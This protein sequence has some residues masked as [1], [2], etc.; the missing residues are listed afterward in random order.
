M[1][2]WIDQTLPGQVE[3]LQ[4]LVRIPSV[5][6]GEKPEPG[7]PFGRKVYE[8]LSYTLDLANRLGFPRTRSLDGYCG[9]VDFGDAD[10]QLLIISHLDVVPAD[11]GWT[12]DPFGGTVRDGRLY[13]RG[14]IDNKSAAVSSLYALAAVKAAGIPLRRSVR[15]LFGC[16]EERGSDC[17]K[18]YRKFEKD[19]TLGFTPDAEYPLV[20]SEKGICQT[21]WKKPFSGSGIRISCGT[22]PNVIPGEA[23]AALPFAAVPCE[24]PEGFTVVFSGN[25]IRATG[26]C[27]HAAEPDL[28]NNALLCLVQV[29]AQQPLS[30]EDLAAATALSAL[31]GLDK[32]GE[33]LGLDIA[34]ESGRLTL[35]PDMLTWDESG[36]TL[37]CDCRY[38]FSCTFEHLLSTLTEC[39]N[40]VGFSLAEHRNAPGLFMA[41]DSELVKT[42]LSVYEEHIGHKA[43]PLAIGG[44]TYARAFPNTVAFGLVKEGEASQCHMPDESIAIEDIR[45]N[46]IV[47]AEAVRRL[48]GK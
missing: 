45:F 37:T 10:E 33:G 14:A 7:M 32:H 5:S 35:S 43:E 20:N 12:F 40:A 21:T 13:G 42:L 18:Y 34:D 19:P 2:Q 30:G 24:A 9:Y 46:T 16:D 36:V 15:L 48:A 8:A 4:G 23:A 6:R 1:K 26:R 38:P 44:G 22:A 28:A 25:E 27:G 11:C 39:F 17:V 31:L 47:I 29:L 41:P 3:A